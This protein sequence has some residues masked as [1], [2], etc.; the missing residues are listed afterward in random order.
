MAGLAA[1]LEAAVAGV[2]AGVD[3]GAGDADGAE[4]HA[5]MRKSDAIATRRRRDI[6][7]SGRLK[8]SDR[9]TVANGEFR[10][11]SNRVHVDVNA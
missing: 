3:A 5:A 10:A 7:S 11:L 4:A 6:E 8:A 9:T 2:T 1:A